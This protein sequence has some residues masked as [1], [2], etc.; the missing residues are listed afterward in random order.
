MDIMQVLQNICKNP[1]A[2]DKGA[3]MVHLI[4][5]EACS[6]VNLGVF[7]SPCRVSVQVHRAHLT[8]CC[9]SLWAIQQH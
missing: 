6:L 2:H 9:Q 5:T 3:D 1:D 7:V 4:H 8:W